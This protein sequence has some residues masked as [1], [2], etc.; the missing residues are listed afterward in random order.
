[1]GN[2]FIRRDS[3]AAGFSLR[4]PEPGIRQDEFQMDRRWRLP[5]FASPAKATFPPASPSGP[6]T[7]GAIPDVLSVSRPCPGD[8]P[9]AQ[10]NESQ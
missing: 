6:A 4:L 9:E 2:G 7:R 1:L 3:A 10:A 8:A 5:S